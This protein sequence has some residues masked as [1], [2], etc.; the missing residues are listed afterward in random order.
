MQLTDKPC[1]EMTSV[2]IA[3]DETDCKKLRLS[4]AFTGT[5][6]VADREPDAEIWPKVSR[7][8]PCHGCEVECHVIF[9]CWM[10]LK[11]ARYC[12]QCASE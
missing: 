5:P 9:M 8:G 7:G 1:L 12:W 3:K 4:D 6:F 10:Q 11:S 2:Q